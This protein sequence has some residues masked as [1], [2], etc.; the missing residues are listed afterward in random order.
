LEESMRRLLFVVLMLGFL[1]LPSSAQTALSARVA[2]IETQ[3]Y[4]QVTVYVSV[5]DPSG[6]FVGGLDSQAFSILEDG[7]PV[8]VDSFAAAGSEPIHAV[9]VIDRSGSMDERRKLEGAQEA[10]LA[11]VRQMR[12]EDTTAI[13]TFSDEPFIA[14]DFTSDRKA[15]E[16]TIEAIHASGATALYDSIIEGVELLQPITGRKALLVLTDGQDQ[17]YAGDSQRAS[18]ASLEEAI[19]VARSAEISVVTIGLGQKNAR[20]DAAGIDERVLRQIAEQTNGQ[21]FYAPEADEL[22]S[23]YERQAD[24]LHNEYVLTYTSPR[25]FY[26]GTRRNI[27][28][29]VNGVAAEETS[30]VE[31]HLI[32][33]HSSPLVGFGLLV[34][35]LALLFAPSLLARRTK[36]AKASVAPAVAPNAISTPVG[37][38]CRDCGAALEP[39]DA[40]FCQACGSD[41]QAPATPKFCDQCSAALRPNSRFCPGCGHVVMP[42]PK[43]NN[44]VR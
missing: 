24:Q 1:A 33:V 14:K 43:P 30:Y 35:I 12:P 11:F 21:Y 6:N 20:N 31:R 41:Q 16:R 37:A 7:A 4:P 36:P 13:I 29:S 23:L 17:F 22:T 27:Q 28:V 42:L 10:A 34:P 2:Q 18:N 19:E 15:L 3:N 39:A 8:T 38:P 44:E 40:R 5:T 26:D 9:L 25:P 32:N